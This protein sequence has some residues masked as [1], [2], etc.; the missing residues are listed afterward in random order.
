MSRS[1]CF[2]LV[3]LAAACTVS[4]IGSLTAR[5][6]RAAAPLTVP[7]MQ[8][9]GQ[10]ENLTQIVA[11]FSEPMRPLGE[12]EQDEAGSPLKLTVPGGKLPAGN[13]RWLD[14][15]TI[16]YL[17]DGPVTVPV[18]IEARI[19][20]G[21]KALSGATLAEEAKFS[22]RTPPLA[23]N[24]S[25]NSPLPP[26]GAAITLNSNYA[27]E[28]GELRSKLRLAL[29]REVLNF[30]L[31]EWET[32]SY[33]HGRK[34]SWSYVAEIK[35]TL[36]AEAK[37]TLTIAAGLNAAGGGE[38]MPERSFTLKTFANLRVEEW[39]SGYRDENDK[40]MRPEEAIHIRFNNPVSYREM[41]GLI[42]VEPP[43]PVN[44]EDAERQDYQSDYFALPFQWAPRTTYTLT[45]QPGLKDAYGGALRESSTFTFKTGD[46]L[47]FFSMESGVKILERKPGADYAGKIPLAVRNLT[48]LNIQLRYAP[49]GEAAFALYRD[50]EAITAKDFKKAP[51]SLSYSGTLDFSKRH[52]ENIRQ[53]LNVPEL[54][55]LPGVEAMAG[56]AELQLNTP[57]RE[58]A[59]RRPQQLG[60][61]KVQITDLGLTY[62][63]G[64]DESLAWVTGLNSGRPLEGVELTLIDENNAVCWQGNTKSDGLAALPGQE[65]LKSPGRLLMARLGDDVSV[66]S[67]N[68]ERLPS[69]HYDNLSR[70]DANRHWNAHM[71]AQLPLYQPGQTVRFALFARVYTDR[72]GEKRLPAGQWLPVANEKLTL[73]I[74]DSRGKVVH[75][76]ESV[77]NAYGSV[78]G[79]FTLSGEANL[80][81]YNVTVQAKRFSQGRHAYG[82]QV[83]SFRPPDFKVDLTAPESRPALLKSD[84]PLKAE[85]DAG[86]FS[87]APLPEA[88][89]VLAVRQADTWF[90]PEL[91]YGY[92][93]GPD[94]YPWHYHGGG[95]PGR[96]GRQ[97]AVVQLSAR[98][99][100]KGHT[101]FTLPELPVTGSKPQ[102]VSL[103][104]TVTDASGLTSQGAAS[105]TLHPAE[106][107]AGIRCPRFAPMG[108]E[109][110]VELK[111]ATW[112]NKPVA[113]AR[114]SL[115]AERQKR[116]TQD[117][118][119]VWEK[120]LDLRNPQGQAWPIAFEKSGA[121]YLSATI[122]DE[123]GRENVS[124]TLVYVPGPDMEWTSQRAEGQL[125]LMPDKDSY[126][127]GDTAVLVVK[128][129]FDQAFALIS[130]ERNGVRSHRVAEVS[131]PSPAV[132]VPLTR[133]DAPYVYAS[134][135]LVRGR[136]SPPP[137]PESGAHDLGSPRVAHGVALLTVNDP[138]EPGLLV[139]AKAD[140]PE[141]RPGG[142]ITLDV[143]VTDRFEKPR[144][145]QVTLLAVDD[146]ILRAAGEQTRYNPAAT[147]VPLQSYGVIS[148]D[149][150]K[151]LLNLSPALMKDLLRR[152]R[153][154]EMAAPAPMAMRVAQEGMN[155]AAGGGEDPA[156]P[157]GNFDPMA[158][159]LAEGETDENGK[160]TASFTL[161]DTLTSYRIVAVAVDT[162]G[163][164]AVV[165]EGVKVNKPL[166]LLSS[167]PRFVTEGDKLEA[168]ILVQN[169]GTAEAAVT[170]EAEAKGMALGEKT[171]SIRLKA[172]ESGMAAFPLEFKNPGLAVLTV[173]GSMRLPSGRETD[174][175]QFVLPVMPAAPLTTVAAAGLLKSGE[176]FTLPV[177]PPAPLDARSRLEV[178]FAASPAAGLPLTA[179]QL[180]EYPWSCL[181][182]RLSRAWLRALRL[183][184]EDLI[185][186]PADPEDRSIIASTLESVEK[187]QQSD[188]G[189]TLWPGLRDSS[190]LYLTTYV[191]LVNSQMEPLKLSID[192]D[193][194]DRAFEFLRGRLRDA[195]QSKPNNRDQMETD[196]L[197]LWLLARTK[198]NS[199]PALFPKV[200]ERA[201]TAKNVNPMAWGALMLANSAMNAVPEP[202]RNERA[203]RIRTA[204]EKSAAITPTQLHFAANN[205]YGYWMTMGSTLRDNAMV[206][207][208]LTATQPDYPR[209]EAL[210][211][212]VS[213]GLGERKN[214]STQEAIF[215]I[216][217][218]AAYLQSLGGNRPVSLKAAWNNGESMTKSFER[219]IDP[220]QT[221]TLPA[222]K[223]A[224]GTQSGQSS[225]LTLSA[226]KGNPYWTARLRYASP[227][228]PLRPENA[229]FTVTRA[230]VTPGPWKMGD[231]V[232]VQITLIVPATRRHVLLF[233]PF[234]AG[235]EPLHASRVDLA[236]AGR[237]YQ[238]PW[239]FQE[240][241]ADGLLLY[242]GQVDPG[243]YTYTYKLRAAAPGVFIQRPTHA[244]EMYTP[245]VF[246]RTTGDSVTVQP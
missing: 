85:L 114:I 221:W 31:R 15:A 8:P 203:G 204:L 52:N 184:H 89:T 233:D 19:P 121:Y 71:L 103:E 127:P 105:F 120:T 223:L 182:Q 91:L 183:R 1:L 156:E 62:R 25:S 157:R 208:A 76:Q 5:T 141:Y 48:P 86:Y 228:V 81:Y 4:L 211:Y 236:D 213:Q 190:S 47:P 56:F 134:I 173:R 104:A 151:S 149:T 191:L 176:T 28:P 200:L 178:I 18:R 64:K 36:P 143:R 20:A 234:P 194:R 206:L 130:V 136:I 21:V 146:R 77:S 231:I 163:H 73:E 27:L 22:L 154:A 118:E 94:A 189:F 107:Y 115:T 162:G 242:S 138:A 222:D 197:A 131:G 215:G 87:G 113:D 38:P 165:E 67:L 209:L 229:G 212:W 174:A 241:R 39:R 193:A 82:F 218:L 170:V 185:G 44:P 175:A 66:V 57:D 37:I 29:G 171:R 220:P 95:F 235:L 41:L 135:T 70:D 40:A 140:K 196:A 16:V 245:E 205:Q 14:P 230:F 192:P 84:P 116:G 169:M 59:L 79:E 186:L 155:D 160:L 17:F 53:F 150:R 35:D 227:S 128:N 99:D 9:Q 12:M 139:A 137:D 109:I 123:Q 83:A 69:D 207:A 80:G 195:Y 74:R 50:G 108:K 225:G 58:D 125:E 201:E 68:S 33:I 158:F 148:A 98:L 34:A 226:L 72:Q 61:V 214:L 216:W 110:M 23:V 142:T 168:R 244:E 238:Y 164:S 65:A 10:V 96:G 6:A 129:P 54:L 199:V 78:S 224:G 42:R 177:K 198:D 32:G 43:A 240:S 30:D 106:L 181:E 24:V 161:P 239:Q 122:K 232:D 111:A 97:D 237:Q 172:G 101:V 102:L 117:R 152:S 167:M 153:M 112:D 55:G 132:E 90:S 63:A 49:W 119:T 60:S 3:F 166:Q 217:G 45:L 88:E 2:A 188:G 126:A 46:Y 219:L 51:G 133:D 75:T 26:T 179:Q 159:W 144:K 13:Y 147:F 93:T 92:K 124:T 202:D 243:T 100:N 187:F 7:T 246:G 145:A 180:I 11:H 210:A